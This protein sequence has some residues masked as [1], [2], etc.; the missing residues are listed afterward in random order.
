MNLTFLRQNAFPGAFI[1]VSGLL[2]DSKRFGG[3]SGSKG[4]ADKFGL[5]SEFC[6]E[7]VGR[8]VVCLHPFSVDP[9]LQKALLL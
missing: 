4:F 9:T 7:S 3:F 5:S 2:I 6:T 1:G 8:R